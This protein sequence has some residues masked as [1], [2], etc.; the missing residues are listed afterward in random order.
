[1]S[2]ED[3]Q[4]K[5]LEAGVVPEEAV[6][7]ME[8]WQAVPAGAS[9]AIGEADLKKVRALRGDLELRGLP[10]IRETIPDLKKIMSNTRKVNLSV[11]QLTLNNVTAGVDRLDR[12]LFQIPKNQDSY[13]ALSSVLRPM[14]ALHDPTKESPESDRHITAVSLIY[15]DQTPTHWFCETEAVGKKTIIKGR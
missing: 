3:L 9:E 2:I 12:Y 15:T 7:Q 11:Q 8:Q 5:I 14:T 1:M 6:K 13:N 10:S 4:K